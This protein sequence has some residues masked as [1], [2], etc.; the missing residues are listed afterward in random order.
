MDDYVT[1]VNI[2]AREE[3]SQLVYLISSYKPP[4][5]VVVDTALV[6][7]FIQILQYTI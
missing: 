3:G 2:A 1:E 6:I 5:W 4:Y 7:R